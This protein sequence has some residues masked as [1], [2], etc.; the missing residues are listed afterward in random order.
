MRDP[1]FTVLDK[2]EGVLKE[3]GPSGLVAELGPSSVNFNIFCWTNSRQASVLTVTDRAMTAIKLTLDEAGID[4][5]Y[6]HTVVL[7]QSV[8]SGD[9]APAQSR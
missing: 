1:S 6:P 9:G 3:P 2:T 8:S 4:I 7:S 5:P